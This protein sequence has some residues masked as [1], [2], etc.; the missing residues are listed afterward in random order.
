MLQTAITKAIEQIKADGEYKHI[1]YQSAC[2]KAIQ[3][4]T[5]LLPYE[6]ETI[7]TAY[8]VGGINSKAISFNG[9]SE[10]RNSQDY[11]TKTYNQ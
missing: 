8:K 11:F 3:I 5:D 6:R 2:D 10:Y 1:H 9:I 7:E 4:L